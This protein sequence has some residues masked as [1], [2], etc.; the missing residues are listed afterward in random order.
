MFIVYCV[1]FHFLFYPYFFAVRV[2]GAVVFSHRVCNIYVLYSTSTYTRMCMSLQLWIEK[3]ENKIVRK[4][5]WTNKMRI[6]R[7]WRMSDI[8]MYMQTKESIFV[9]HRDLYGIYRYM[10][11]SVC[12]HFS[13]LFSSLFFF[14]FDSF[15]CLFWFCFAI[16]FVHLKCYCFR[17]RSYL[18]YIYLNWPTGC[19]KS[20]LYFLFFCFV[21]YWKHLICSK[22]SMTIHSYSY[23]IQTN[24]SMWW[25]NFNFKIAR[26]IDDRQQG[27]Y[28]KCKIQMRITHAIEVDGVWNEKKICGEEE[29]GHED[30]DAL[31]NDVSSTSSSSSSMAPLHEMCLWWYIFYIAHTNM[32]TV[33]FYLVLCPILYSSFNLNFRSPSRR[34][35][36]TSQVYGWFYHDNHQV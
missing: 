19:L 10:Y 15:C 14:F 26:K 17:W 8:H 25:T 30:G 7:W 12:V 13:S 21:V 4:I 9:L 31:I 22:D 28:C 18:S 5:K 33:V 35:F 11:V 23:I 1:I 29:N 34:M 36:S 27:C 2:N 6:N 32:G 16:F 24:A 20:E 3:E